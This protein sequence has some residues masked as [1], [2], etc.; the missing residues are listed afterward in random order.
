MSEKC[1]AD[2]HPDCWIKCDE[3]CMA[4]YEEPDGPCITACSGGGG[5]TINFSTSKK[6]SVQIKNMPSSALEKILGS[7]LNANLRSNLKSSGKL[8]SLN[9]HSVSFTEIAAAIERSMQ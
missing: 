9:V 6:V 4:W 3:G 5:D 7:H 2:G 8:I 1:V